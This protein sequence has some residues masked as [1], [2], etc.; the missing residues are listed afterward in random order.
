MPY[1]DGASAWDQA[2]KRIT[3]FEINRSEETE[4]P[5]DLDIRRF[6]GYRYEKHL[7]LASNDLEGKNSFEDPER[8]RPVEKTDV[9]MEA[10]IYKTHV[11]PLSWNVFCFCKAEK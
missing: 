8:F 2:S 7:E 6:E 4:Y 10:G 3:V 1:I 5:L 9:N 11:K